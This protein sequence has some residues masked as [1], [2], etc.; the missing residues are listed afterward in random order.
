MQLRK[1][2]KK[3]NVLFSFQRRRGT[4]NTFHKQ[5]V[6]RDS[7]SEKFVVRQGLALHLSFVL[8]KSLLACY[9]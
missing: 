6:L 2:K 8:R 4:G 1:T 5:R 7:F 3:I 9:L